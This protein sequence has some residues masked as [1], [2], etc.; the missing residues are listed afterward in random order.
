[1]AVLQDKLPQVHLIHILSHQRDGFHAKGNHVADL[2]AKATMHTTKLA[3]MTQSQTKINT[4]I[5]TAIQATMKNETPPICFPLKSFYT[6]NSDNT[7]VASIAGVGDRIIPNK[8]S[9]LDLIIA[10]HE[11]LAS[12]H[13]GIGATIVMLQQRYW[14]PG[15]PIQTRKYVKQCNIC[16]QIKVSTV[17][18]PQQTPLTISNL[19]FRVIY[20]DHVRPINSVN[21]NKYIFVAIDSCSRF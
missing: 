18:R 5:L 21:Q 7:A 12:A 16:Q 9:R 8:L 6:L 14:W 10:T 1:M 19:P 2:S 11:G 13:A 3:A 4:K 15:L 17:K 20:V